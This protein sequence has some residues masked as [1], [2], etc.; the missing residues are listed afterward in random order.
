MAAKVD[1]ATVQHDAQPLAEDAVAVAGLVLH[2]VH[3]QRAGQLGV[4]QYLGRGQP[5]L[6]TA[7]GPGEGRRG[8]G[9]V[10]VSGVVMIR[11]IMIMWGRGVR[12]GG[13]GG[14]RQSC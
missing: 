13:G 14:G 2:G 6:L 8:G 3:Q 7:V 4:G 11:T 12:A 5:L 9:G 1:D 10:V